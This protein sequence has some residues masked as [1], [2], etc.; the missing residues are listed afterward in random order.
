M[1]RHRV[2]DQDPSFLQLVERE[3][4]KPGRALKVLSR[5]RAADTVVIRRG[6]GDVLSL[7][8]RAASKIAVEAAAAVGVAS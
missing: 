5:D 1:D 7:G 4:L 8:Y 3:G 2:L 6:D